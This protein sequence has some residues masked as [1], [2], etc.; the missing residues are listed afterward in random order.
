MPLS[1]VVLRSIN[2]THRTNVFGLVMREAGTERFFVTGS[3]FCE[4]NQLIMKICGPFPTEPL[5]YDYF[6]QLLAL[7]DL[8]VQYVAIT[9][10]V[11]K[12][13]I[14]KVVAERRKLFAVE[15]LVEIE[16]RPSDA[17]LLSVYTGC[18]IFVVD[19]LLAKYGK[20]EHE[21]MVPFDPYHDFWQNF[22]DVD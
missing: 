12:V 9:A 14:A 2:A 15:E 22:I 21:L 18:P 7:T 5:P 20:P 8:K 16:C 17:V 6:T 19:D 4:A 13:F 11:D 3:G 1:K 10:E